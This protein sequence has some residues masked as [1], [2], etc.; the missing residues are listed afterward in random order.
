M[1]YDFPDD[2]RKAQSDLEQVRGDLACL[3]ARLPYS[4]EPIEA[5]E[6]PE[7]YWRDGSPAYPDSPGWTPE[8]QSQVAALREREQELAV[9]IVT[10]TYWGTL[11]PAE[12][13]A[14]RDALKHAQDAQDA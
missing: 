6:R 2:L 8:E 12:R 7:G 10:H 3:I 1:K 4:V 11:E 13:P 9:T 5:W 14:A